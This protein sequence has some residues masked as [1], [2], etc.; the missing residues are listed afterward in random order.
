MPVAPIGVV[1]LSSVTDRL[2]ALITDCRDHSSLWNPQNLVTNPGPPFTITP[3][4][5][6]PEAVRDQGDCQLTLYLFH[7]AENKFQKNLEP[8][9]KTSPTVPP[10]QYI[11]L[12]LDLYYLLTAFAKGSYAQEQQA[13][14]MAMRCLHD[15]AIVKLDVVLGGQA[16]K[17]EFTVTMEAEASDELARLWQSFAV[18]PRLSAV[19]RVSVALISPEET[20]GPVSP[21]PTVVTITADPAVLPF[22]QGGQVVGTGRRF[23]YRK[24]DGTMSDPIDMAPATA[25]PNQQFFLYGAGLNQGT[26]DHVYLTMPGNVEVDVS[27][28]LAPAPAVQTASRLTLVLPNAIGAPAPASPQP[29]VYLLSVGDAGTLRSNATAFTIAPRVDVTANPP[30]LTGPTFTVNG[31]GFTPGQTQVLLGTVPL[32]EGAAGAGFFQLNG[33]GTQIT[34]QAP[35]GLPAGRHAVRI[36]VNGVEA[37]PSWWI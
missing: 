5:L 37:D 19:Y 36:R 30:I 1:D 13:M 34:F 12:A 15:N 10:I 35:G 18:P 9:G 6:S 31:I 16:I 24:P 22:A 32:T 33:L 14:T 2:I 8:V 29:G 23:R 17:E 28:W 27:G 3:S 26:S 11:P 20:I 25:V 7:V 4:G 21:K